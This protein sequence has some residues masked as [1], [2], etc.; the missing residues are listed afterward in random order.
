MTYSQIFK[1]KS[2]IVGIV[3]SQKSDQKDG[4]LP[5]NSHKFMQT[6]PEICPEIVQTKVQLWYMG[7]YRGN[8][9]GF[10]STSWVLQKRQNW[11]LLNVLGFTEETQTKLVFVDRLGFSKGDKIVSVER[12]GF[13]IG[14]SDKIGFC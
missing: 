13:H 7:F 6:F 2:G 12:L 1:N 14:D 5:T 4:A 9:I 10:C 11:F 3:F 8:K